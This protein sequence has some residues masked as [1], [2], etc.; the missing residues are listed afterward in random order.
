MRVPE[1]CGG[2]VNLGLY[3]ENVRYLCD[4][5]MAPEEEMNY[6]VMASKLYSI[7]R[8]SERIYWEFYAGEG[9]S[10]PN[11]EDL[12]NR[13]Y[14]TIEDAESKLPIGDFKMM[15]NT[16]RISTNQPPC[17]EYLEFLKHEYYKKG[18]ANNGPF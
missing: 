11:Y 15:V 16:H 1:R 6:D 2:N 4:E 14:T 18:D 10:E 12:I 13:T 5:I 3:N 17:G 9:L 8:H 7:Y